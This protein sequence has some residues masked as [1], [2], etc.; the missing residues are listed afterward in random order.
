MTSTRPIIFANHEIYHVYNRGVEKRPIFITTRDYQRMVDTFHYYQ[1][2]NTSLRFSHYLLLPKLDRVNYMQ[3]IIKKAIKG[4]AILAY[5]LMPNHFHFMI[6]QLQE[7]GI[8]HFVAN[9]TNSYTKYFNTK[10]KRV[11]PL[12]QGAF[13]AVRVESDEQLIHLSRYIHLNPVSAFLIRLNKLDTY[14]WSSFMEYMGQNDSKICDTTQVRNHFLTIE[15]YKQFVFDQA[16]Y[17]M[18]SEKIKFISFD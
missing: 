3:D 15:R 6:K 8:S 2:I 12:V 5:C 14:R 4:V 9:V 11:G 13:K 16:A 17:T 7:D 1:Y 18:T 10:N